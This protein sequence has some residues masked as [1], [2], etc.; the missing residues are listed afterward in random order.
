MDANQIIAECVERRKLSPTKSPA[1]IVGEVMDEVNS[2]RAAL[3]ARSD[4]E[5]GAA[6]AA[7]DKQTSLPL[8]K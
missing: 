3:R 2:Y 7:D 5:T 1:Q 8:D 4:F 6:P